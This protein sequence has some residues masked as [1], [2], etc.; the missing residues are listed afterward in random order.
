MKHDLNSYVDGMLNELEAQV[1][2]SR[3]MLTFRD[4]PVLSASESHNSKRRT[5]QANKSANSSSSA[6]LNSSVKHAKSPRFGSKSTC[7]STPWMACHE[8]AISRRLRDNHVALS[9]LRDESQQAFAIAQQS[10]LELADVQNLRRDIADPTQR[11]VICRRRRTCADE[12]SCIVQ[13][14]KSFSTTKRR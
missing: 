2:R 6:A 1:C 9:K 10:R 5:M 3:Y 7:H 14:C 8:F 11:F 13:A 4:D 12:S